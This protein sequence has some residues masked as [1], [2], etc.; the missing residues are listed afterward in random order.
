MT[1][2]NIFKSA[3]L[4]DHIPTADELRDKLDPGVDPVVT[5]L[6]AEADILQNYLDIVGL[7]I[8]ANGVTKKTFKTELLYYVDKDHKIT[9]SLKHYKPETINYTIE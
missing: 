9:A 7:K 1:R 6:P 3:K 4:W 2:I 8:T 5:Q